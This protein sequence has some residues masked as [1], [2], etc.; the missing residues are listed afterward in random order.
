VTLGD[1]VRKGRVIG[2]AIRQSGLLGTLRPGKVASY[3]LHSLGKPR[4]PTGVLRLHATNSPDRAALVDGATRL[5]YG[6][7]DERVNRLATALAGQGVKPGDRVALM[8]RNC[9]QYLELQWAIMRLGAVAVQ[10]GYRLKAP[11]VAFI[12][13]NSEPAALFY[14]SVDEE[15]VRAAV[16]EAALPHLRTIPIGPKYEALLAR[17]DPRAVP[18][19]PREAAGVMIYTSGTT[20]CPKGASRGFKESFHESVADFITKVGIRADERHLCVCPLYHSAAPAFCA[21]IFALGGTVVVMEHFEAEAV[22]A[23]IAAEKITSAFL[24]PTMLARLAAVPDAYDTHALRWLASGAAPLPTATARD[25]EA[26]FGRILYN[27]YGAT[28]TG[29]VTLACPGEHTARPGTIGRPLSGNEIRLYD[30]AG[31]EVPPGD[32]GEI[33]VR[34]SMLVAGYHGNPEAT[35]SAMRDG[36]FSVGDMARADAD[37]YYYLADRKIDMVI[38][39]GVNIYPLEIEQRIHAHPAVM[40][41]AVVGVPDPEWGES[42]RA[43]VVARPGQAV[44]GDEVRAFCKQALAN[45]K[46]PKD[47]VFLETLPRNPTG[48]VLKRELRSW[49]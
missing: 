38:S 15:T 36:F 13:G 4:N 46:C 49:P 16:A 37:G 25:V 29:L 10:I 11:E 17:G 40:E 33:Y 7:L 30:D 27:F 48:K 43:F 35:R 22:L 3:V 20:G 34:N 42:L 2:G 31:R 6:E 39:G 24:V 41:C 9:H 19:P 28:E 8:L 5:T 26:R 32:V 1:F 23:T 12:L 47:V 44:T 45:Y 18:R 21:F 14:Q